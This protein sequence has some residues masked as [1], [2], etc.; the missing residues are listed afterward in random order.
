VKH[1][2]QG[3][4]VVGFTGLGEAVVNSLIVRDALGGEQKPMT[5]P[6]QSQ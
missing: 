2:I 4:I 6:S 3:G 5:A 1:P